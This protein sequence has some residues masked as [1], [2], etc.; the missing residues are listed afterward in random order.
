M[1][2]FNGVRY[3]CTVTLLFFIVR[4]FLLLVGLTELKYVIEECSKGVCKKHSDVKKKKSSVG[5]LVSEALR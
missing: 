3:K 1:S 5:T 4:I 2:F